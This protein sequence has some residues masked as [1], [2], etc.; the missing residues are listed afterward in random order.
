[1]GIVQGC[2]KQLWEASP[3]VSDIG[4]ERWTGEQG[5]VVVVAP[6]ESLLGNLQWLRPARRIQDRSTSGRQGL[7]L[8]WVNHWKSRILDIPPYHSISSK[9]WELTFEDAAGPITK[10]LLTDNGEYIPAI[11]G[12]FL[13]IFCKPK[14][15]TLPLHQSTDHAID[16]V[17]GYNLP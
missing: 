12:E 9:K 1:M 8:P 17:P 11:Y 14:A 3:M 15:E 7:A 6:A 4:P 2:W 13:D 10:M 16:L 5:A